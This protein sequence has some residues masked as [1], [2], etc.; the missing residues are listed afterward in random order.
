MARKRSTS[1]RPPATTGAAAPDPDKP[2]PSPQISA[3]PAIHDVV[4]SSQ[5]AEAPRTSGAEEAA[6]GMPATAAPDSLDAALQRHGL[7]LPAS[8]AALLAQY[9][10]LLWDWNQKLNLT[11]HTDYERF[12]GRDLVDTLQLAP[13]LAPGESVL[14]VGTGGGVP[15]LVLAILRPDL[16]ITLCDSVQK[17]A[18]AV[19][20]IVAALGL[21]VPVLPLRAEQVLSDHR[22]D[23]LVIRAVGPLP[24]LLADFRRRW[25]MFRRML[26]FKG[27]RWTEELAEARRRG[28]LRGLSCQVRAEYPLATG[29]G[30]SV[31]L[32]IR[33]EKAPPQTKASR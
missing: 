3:P 8:Q 13:L 1:R 29:T 7:S 14:D 22:F 12:V 6:P 24:K 20:S 11:R 18:R 27:P 21:S 15:G 2:K 25:P 32:E 4:H 26:V 5:P 28:L 17:K 31:V 10:Q 33:P 23:T 30:Q 9:C 19:A 16:D